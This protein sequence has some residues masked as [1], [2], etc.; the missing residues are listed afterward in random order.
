MYNINYIYEIIIIHLL[1]KMKSLLVIVL[2]QLFNTM[3]FEKHINDLK[4][5]S[6]LKWAVI[7]LL[8]TL[9]VSCADMLGLVI[10]AEPFFQT[11]LKRN[12]GLG[13]GVLAFIGYL[14]GVGIAV[15]LYLYIP[16]FT[17]NPLPNMS[18]YHYKA[19][20]Q[21][22]LRDWNVANQGYEKIIQQ[23]KKQLGEEVTEVGSEVSSVEQPIIHEGKIGTILPSLHNS[24]SLETSEA[25]SIQHKIN[26]SRQR[27]NR[28]VAA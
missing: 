4:S 11:G 17:Q 27:R 1:P 6:Q 3:L 21:F 28:G 20:P 16:T 24:A 14:S 2:Y 22:E 10:Q 26:Q 23:I 18:F 13:E 15:W 19:A 7:L 8:L 25:E 12:L 9:F 5:S